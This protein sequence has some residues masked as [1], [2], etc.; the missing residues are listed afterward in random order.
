MKQKKWSKWAIKEALRHASKKLEDAEA[1][2][3][4]AS[5]DLD[6]AIDGL[7][8]AQKYYMVILAKAKKAGMR[9]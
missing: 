3:D 1:F 5:H 9:V 8:E 7:I 6:D 2:R 4:I